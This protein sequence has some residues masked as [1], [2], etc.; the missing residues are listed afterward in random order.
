MLRAGFVAVLIGLAWIGLDSTAQAQPSGW[1]FRWQ[2]G[3]VL[4]YRVE[5]I[6]TAS[7]TLGDRKD[8]SK[9]KLNLVKRWQV[10]GVDGAGVATLQLSLTS[11]RM[12]TTTPRGDV[13]VF[14]SAAPEKCDAKLKEQLSQYVGQ[15]LAVLRVDAKGKV[16]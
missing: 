2:T 3:Q 8:E 4:T 11:M 13:I 5:Q 1:R 12:E 16:I 7:E 14:D 6:T 15:P 10:Q 9:T